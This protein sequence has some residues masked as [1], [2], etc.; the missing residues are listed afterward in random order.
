M[1]FDL[2]G[3]QRG[4][5]RRSAREP[6]PGWPMPTEAVRLPDGAR[7]RL[8][9]VR[10][11]DGGEWRRQRL[12]DE[13]KLRPVEPTVPGGWAASHTASAWW[14]YFLSL[15]RLAFAGELIPLAVEVDGRFLGQLTIGSIQRGTVCEAW[16]GYWVFSPATGRGVA[17]AATALGVDLAFG[18]VGLHRLT[19]TFLPEN[20]ASGRVLTGNGFRVEGLLRRNIHIDGVWRDHYLAGLNR[21]DFAVPAVERLRRAGRL[22]RP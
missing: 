12:A 2:F 15:R 6:H 18:A 21:E 16:L 11:R 3:Q 1:V 17:T 20:P 8:R 19:A 13:P 10:A 9:P 7:V 22:R 14:S 4:P 5:G